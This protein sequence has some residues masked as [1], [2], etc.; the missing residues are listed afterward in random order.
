MEVPR[1]SDR[2]PYIA[3]QSYTELVSK[4]Y[5]I[6]NP[7]T[8]LPIPRPALPSEALCSISTLSN[9]KGV[10]PDWWRLIYRTEPIDPFRHK[11]LGIQANSAD[12]VVVGIAVAGPIVGE[13]RLDGGVRPERK[14]VDR[15]NHAGGS[16]AGIARQDRG[17]REKGP[18]WW[19]PG[20]KSPDADRGGTLSDISGSPV[21]VSAQFGLPVDDQICVIDV[22]G[23][24]S[25]SERAKAH[26]PGRARIGAGDGLAV[27][28]CLQA[29][30][31]ERLSASES[32]VR[33]RPGR[34][35]MF[36]I[37]TDQAVYLALDPFLFVNRR[38]A[39][40]RRLSSSMTRNSCESVRPS[41]WSNPGVGNMCRVAE[42]PPL[43]S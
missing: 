35:M 39:L 42:R 38:S 6:T 24:L 13:D 29:A 37:Q 7:A 34:S 33:Y 32:N 17:F 36:A 43:A 10:W 18:N 27:L 21:Y 23:S 16:P 11:W 15:R 26:Q 4:S 25:E 31:P 2:Q 28:V 20:G 1:Q 19:S 14:H 3:S 12:P 22:V 30:V 8:Y 40:V 5:P 41:A 9:W